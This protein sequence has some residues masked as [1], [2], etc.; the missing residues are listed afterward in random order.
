MTPL[1]QTWLIQHFD[2]HVAPPSHESW[3]GGSRQ[4]QSLSEGVERE[5]FQRNY[6][7]EDTPL[8]HVEFALKYD[9][10]HLELLRQVFRRVPRAEVVAWVA[11]QPTGKWA[12]RI[13]YLYEFLGGESLDPASLGVGG[14]YAPLLDPDRY[15]TAAPPRKVAAWRIE[16]NLLGSAEFCP[17]VRRTPALTKGLALD[18]GARLDALRARYSPVLF[19]RAA[20]Y[21]YQ[22]ETRSS[23]DIEREAP[24]PDREARFVAA[25]HD[26][27][28][29]NAEAALSEVR[30]VQLQNL[31][32]DPRYAQATFRTEQN[33]VGETLPD[34]R[35]HI[36]FV[37]PPPQ[38]VPSLMRG[39]A[40]SLLASAGA[41]ALV[42]AAAVAFG[43]VFV[44]P[45]EDGNGRL[46]RFLIHDILA[47][48]GFVP[49]GVVLPVSAAMLKDMAGY[50]RCLEM[51]SR[52]LAELIRYELDADYGLTVL[53]PDAVEGYYRYPDMTAQAEYLCAAVTAALERELE[54]ELLFLAGFDSA[55]VALRA[56]VD[57]PDRKL[58]L[59]IK[60]LHQ[61]RGKLSAGKR[62]QFAE[63]SDAELACMEAAYQ[64]AFAKGAASA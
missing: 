63:I 48:D 44:H 56:V 35:Q 50:D 58:N 15:I 36:H 24:S 53:N 19:H 25:L 37:P 32:V 18:V 4:S 9:H 43:F 45:F 3:L 21:L 33:Y 2:L 42:R 39:L 6:A 64:E 28:Q 10:L 12:R 54:P 57:M 16:D 26:A 52:P 34:Y 51:F 20:G 38:F 22:K 11:N 40:Q 31:I 55:R 27:G 62:A 61:N 1:G 14:N 49:R 47:L 41:P 17:V 46:H 8:A 7:P 30:L 29:V 59:L 60:L 23:Y 13:G 5:S